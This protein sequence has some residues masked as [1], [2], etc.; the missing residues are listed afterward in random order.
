MHGF[1]RDERQQPSSLLGSLLSSLKRLPAII[2]VSA[3][4]LSAMLLVDYLWR[5]YRKYFSRGVQEAI[6]LL[7][8]FVEG[9]LMIMTCLTLATIV[10]EDVGAFEGMRRA[11]AMVKDEV[12]PL[13]RGSTGAAALNYEGALGVVFLPYIAAFALTPLYFAFLGDASPIGQRFGIVGASDFELIVYAALALSAVCG[14]LY[15]SLLMLLESV[16]GSG[17]YLFSKSEHAVDGLSSPEV[18]GFFEK[19]FGT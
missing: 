4:V 19:V 16:L 5:N 17:L 1:I 3:L 11:V 13:L 9:G 8:A 18:L 12:R 15:F 10:T 7:L 2:A 14:A 6:Q